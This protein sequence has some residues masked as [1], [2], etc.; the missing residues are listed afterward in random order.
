MNEQ[1]THFAVRQLLMCYILGCC[2]FL[3]AGSY[4]MQQFGVWCA[5]ISLI[6]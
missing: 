3:L 6:L 4:L 2:Q 1:F 5:H